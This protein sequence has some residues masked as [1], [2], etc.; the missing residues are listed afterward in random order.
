MPVV[1]FVTD[2]TVFF[3]GV[4]GDCGIHKIIFVL[5]HT[6]T[7]SSVY[8]SV[9]SLELGCACWKTEAVCI[10]ELPLISTWYYWWSHCV[11]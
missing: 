2:I 8:M 11:H 9:V 6:H 1:M 3:K 4:D 7:L 5:K 10:N